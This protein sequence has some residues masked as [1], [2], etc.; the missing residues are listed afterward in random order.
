MDPPM[1][2]KDRS[3]HLTHPSDYRGQLDREGPAE[4]VSLIR[5]AGVDETDGRS[6]TLRIAHV[7]EGSSA[8]GAESL[9]TLLMRQAPF[10]HNLL[11]ISTGSPAPSTATI[12]RGEHVLHVLQRKP[13]LDWNCSRR[14]AKLL[15]RDRVGLI[16]AHT[17]GAFFYGMLARLHY[18][19]PPILFTEHRRRHPDTPSPR[20]VSVNRMFLENRDRIVASSRSVRQA[21]ILNEGLP[22]E[23]VEVIYNGVGPPRPQNAEATRSVRR[24]LG[25]EPEGL[26]VLQS[27]PF[28]SYH[29]HVLAIRAMEQVVRR[30]PNA[31]LVLVGEGPELKTIGDVV[32]RSGMEDHV[33]FE[34]EVRDLGELLPAADLVLST[35]LGDA[36]PESVIMALA[37]GRPVVGTRMGGVA[38]VVDDRACGLLS[39]PGDYVGLAEVICLLAT[40]PDLRGIYGAE[41][42]RRA[43]SMFSEIATARNY[44]EVYRSMLSQRPKPGLSPY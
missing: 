10:N 40:R 7:F 21:L 29:D 24:R 18:R 9:A 31:R 43:E 32:R 15:D 16:H 17:A 36:V 35:H 41:A 2:S 38:E 28:D 1:P 34:G 22:P 25:V 3:T 33:R 4:G 42:R 23:Q 14:L 30:L 39:N 20:R 37:A 44:A 6:P 13:G 11:V 12:A 5:N 26:M 27:A 8:P 19:R